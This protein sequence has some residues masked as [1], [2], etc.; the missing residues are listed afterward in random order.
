[1]TEEQRKAVLA[2]GVESVPE[3]IMA[4]LS[5]NH[6]RVLD[7]FR[8]MDTNF[9]GKISRGEFSHALR[10]LGLTV[11]PTETERV[12]HTLDPDRSGTVEY[13]ELRK[14]L[15]DKERWKRP[16]PPPKKL[17]AGQRAKQSY[18]AKVQRYELAEDLYAFELQHG[19][20]DEDEPDPTSPF[21]QRPPQA[22]AALE[23]ER[24]EM[25]LQQAL[26]KRRAHG[27]KEPVSGPLA[28]RMD[29]VWVKQPV[30]RPET[31][32]AR[33]AHDRAVAQAKTDQYRSWVDKHRTTIEAH[34][35]AVE[36]EIIDDKKV[37]K[38]RVQSARR[39]CLDTLH[40]KK[41]ATRLAALERHDLFESR[42]EAQQNR[43][44]VVERNQQRAWKQDITFLTDA[45]AAREGG[46]IRRDRLQSRT[47]SDDLQSEIQSVLE[48]Q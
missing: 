34:R 41:E 15:L 44:A 43:R 12:F 13:E 6:A 9:D 25:L 30:Q 33:A 40:K 20:L 5:A 24:K 3:T 8:S 19:L 46:G 4:T 23:E 16:P 2:G 45:Q 48:L 47:R 26:E 27:G 21:H 29:R 31:A 39:V 11:S 18:D 10:S 42:R 22:T 14:A 28:H 32:P 38:E 17:T 35:L 7:W 1:M 36:Q 37:R